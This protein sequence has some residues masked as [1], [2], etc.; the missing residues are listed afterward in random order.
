MIL[1]ARNTLFASRKGYIMSISGFY[2]YASLPPAHKEIITTFVSKANKKYNPD[3]ITLNTWEEMCI[4][5]KILIDVI[6]N[7]I[8]ESSFFCADITYY[9]PNVMFE[10][11][12]AIAKGKR[13][14]LSVESGVDTNEEQ[15]RIFSFLSVV[16]YAEYGNSSNLLDRF[17]KD[18]PHADLSSTLYRSIIEPYIGLREPKNKAKPALLYLKP[19]FDNE[20]CNRANA[21]IEDLDYIKTIDDPTETFSQTIQWYGEKV[22]NADLVIC[23]MSGRRRPKSETINSRHAFFCGM[24]KGL[25]KDIAIYAEEDYSVPLD[26][27]DNVCI[28]QTAQMGVQHLE[29]FIS[30]FYTRFKP[31]E[32]FA[33][34]VNLNTLVKLSELNIGDILAENENKDMLDECFIKTNAYEEAINGRN[35]IFVGRK[36]SGKTACFLQLEQELSKNRR[37][38]VVKIAPDDYE[39]ASIL[40]VLETIKVTEKHHVFDSLWKYLIYTEI[41]LAVKQEYTRLNGCAS[42]EAEKNIA[43]IINDQEIGS[44]PFSIRIESCLR[45]LRTR[46]FQFDLTTIENQ[47]GAISQILHAEFISKARIALGKYLENKQRVAILVDNLDK[48]WSKKI[49]VDFLSDILW[50]LL[51]VGKNL[52]DDFRHTDSRKEQVKANFAIF[53]RED[54]FDV[55][56]KNSREPDKISCHSMLWE[57]SELLFRLIDE[58]LIF[59]QPRKL[60][61]ANRDTLWNNYFVKTVENKNVMEYI[62]EC[63]IPRPRDYLFLMNAAISTA[64]NRR[65]NIVEE[66]D[67]LKAEEQYSKYAVETIEVEHIFEENTRELIYSL[68]GQNSIL[69]DNDINEIAKRVNVEKTLFLETLILYGVLSVC[70]SENSFKQ[71][72]NIN[73]YERIIRLAKVNSEKQKYPMSWKITRAFWKELGI[74]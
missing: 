65:H 20:F 71:V 22:T 33:K 1:P 61:N 4:N 66:S 6:C 48:A 7:K 55:I 42:T 58:R 53:L 12:Y 8:D 74:E 21:L 62:K 51:R 46:T 70:I 35:M 68:I 25:G 39:F 23:N 63:C 19:L 10:L 31:D 40:S 5:G 44:Q 26:F 15:K 59:N 9:N 43:A 28:Y 69:K 64:K 37:N 57:D 73:D 41:L 47:R 72:Y 67:F 52:S 32:N 49:H 54:I 3:N 36:G 50:S 16:G 30:N 17:S 2:A 18:R 38:L 45:N 34:E 60:K 29:E 27:K 11:G 14:W 56:R 13:I 24:A